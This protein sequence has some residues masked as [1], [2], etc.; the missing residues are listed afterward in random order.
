[1]IQQPIQLM[2]RLTTTATN[3]K[4]TSLD[5]IRTGFGGVDIPAFMGGLRRVC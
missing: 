5:V 2:A 3:L 4:E 1:M